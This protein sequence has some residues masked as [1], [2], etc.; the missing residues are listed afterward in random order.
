[1]ALKLGWI[2]RYVRST[3]KWTVFP[4]NFEMDDMYK[5]GRNYVDR[6][7]EITFNPFWKNGVIFM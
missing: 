4:K 7:Y 2:K 3:A 1:M 5:Y 6:I